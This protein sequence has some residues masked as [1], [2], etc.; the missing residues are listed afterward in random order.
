MECGTWWLVLYV[1]AWYIWCAGLGYEMSQAWSG[2]TGLMK[3]NNLQM[4]CRCLACEMGLHDTFYYIP[5]TNWIVKQ[6]VTNV[7]Q[8]NT[9]CANSKKEYL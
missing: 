6:R 9:A 1:D 4:M 8:H 3:K 7:Q 5:V 2:K